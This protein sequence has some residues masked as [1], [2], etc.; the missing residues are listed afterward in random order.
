MAAALPRLAAQ[1]ALTAPCPRAPLPPLGRQPS[2]SS[3]PSEPDAAPPEGEATPRPS[4]PQTHGGG[5]VP[6]AAPGGAP[7]E[8]IGSD[9]SDDSPVASLRRSVRS[10]DD[11]VEWKGAGDERVANPTPMDAFCAP[12]GSVVSVDTPSLQNDGAT[13]LDAMNPLEPPTGGAVAAAVALVPRKA[14]SLKIKKSPLPHGLMRLGPAR[15]KRPSL[16]AVPPTLQAG[17]GA[18]GTYFAEFPPKV[19]LL[20]ALTLPFAAAAAGVIAWAVASDEHVLLALLIPPAAVW[21]ALVYHCAG[22]WVLFFEDTGKHV[23]FRRAHRVFPC[24][25]DAFAIGYGDVTFEAAQRGRRFRITVLAR[26]SGA[27]RSFTVVDTDEEA[28][29]AKWVAFL[30]PRCGAQEASGH[31]IPGE[32]GSPR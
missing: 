3:A 14:R 13:P 1:P 31:A 22:A 10:E 19:S 4:Q 28:E 9:A 21:I 16:C 15:T 8:G 12:R 7:S 25:T 30:A 20:C 32:H 6:G 24:A 17:D 23:W 29:S 11:E 18:A 2:N 27:A 26:Q 5:R